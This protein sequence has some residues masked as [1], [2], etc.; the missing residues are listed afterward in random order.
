MPTRVPEA[1]RPVEVPLRVKT[2]RGPVARGDRDGASGPRVK[3]IDGW[4]A[5]IMGYGESSCPG[6]GAA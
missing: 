4:L 3:L 6:A 5:G 1:G 2:L